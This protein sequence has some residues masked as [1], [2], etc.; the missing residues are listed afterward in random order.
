[1]M[2][3]VLLAALVC[4]SPSMSTKDELAI[5][6]LTTFIVGR[7]KA[8]KRAARVKA[9][10]ALLA[11]R[12]VIEARRYD[13]PVVMFATIAWVESWYWRWCEG[14]SH[15]YGIWQIWP[16]SS[17]LKKGWDVLRKQK[18]IG[19]H[20]DKPWKKISYADRRKVM[21]DI[22]VS[23]ALAAYIFHQMLSWCRR[24]HRYNPK[25]PGAVHLREIDRAGHY[26]SGYAWPKPAY[27]YQL[28]RYSRILRA[29]LAQ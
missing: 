6:R 27:Y 23:T 26:N 13:I 1:M 7:H 19:N 12:I 20:P 15:E 18:R 16:Y 17:T 2:T 4:N 28:R 11:R 10:A 9:Y 14:T 29:A 8:P 3:A 21:G 22:T 25:N 24:K 5:K